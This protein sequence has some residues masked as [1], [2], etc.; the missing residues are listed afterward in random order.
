MAQIIEQRYALYLLRTD[1]SCSIDFVREYRFASMFSYK[2]LNNDD[3]RILKNIKVRDLDQD[4]SLKKDIKK[5]IWKG[6]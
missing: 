4:K 6:D 1:N 3:L 5:W 2:G